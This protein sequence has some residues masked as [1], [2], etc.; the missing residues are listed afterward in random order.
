MITVAVDSLVLFVSGP[1]LWT[2]S[3]F[4]K[5]G[6]TECL[7]NCFQSKICELVSG[8]LSK[9]SYIHSYTH[10][11]TSSVFWFITF[12]TAAPQNVTNK[13]HKSTFKQSLRD[14]LFYVI[15]T[16]SYLRAQ[17]IKMS[18]LPNDSMR[19]ML[20]QIEIFLGILTVLFSCKYFFKYSRELLVVPPRDFASS[21]SL[22]FLS[23]Q[24]EM[25]HR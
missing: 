2:E 13:C 5:E 22:T 21:D 12:K 18:S 11:I 24:T 8:E 25:F 19:L 9:Y 10:R 1:V 14:F 3:N 23:S 6:E 20:K 7:P 4:P 15:L 17:T 16:I